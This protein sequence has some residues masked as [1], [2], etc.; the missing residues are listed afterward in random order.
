[1]TKNGTPP[2]EFLRVR[3]VGGGGGVWWGGGG[4]ENQDE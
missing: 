4:G 2:P 3:G 1:M